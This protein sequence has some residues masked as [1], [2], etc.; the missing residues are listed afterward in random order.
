M[1]RHDDDLLIRL[2]SMFGQYAK[3][4]REDEYIRAA[5]NARNA[6]HNEPNNVRRRINRINRQPTLFYVGPT[7]RLTPEQRAALD[8]WRGTPYQVQI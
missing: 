5:H 4:S 3:G 6:F 8:H 7:L 1:L 2:N